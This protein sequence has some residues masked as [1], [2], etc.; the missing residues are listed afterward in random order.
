GDKLKIIV[1]CIY[2]SPASDPAEF[3]RTLEALLTYLSK[4][5]DHIILAGGDLNGDFDITT[6]KATVAD[7][8]NLLRQFNC[9]C[10]NSSP[11]RGN[12]CLDN[13]FVNCN[14]D[15]ILCN[16]KSFP[17]SDNDGLVIGLKAIDHFA[18][19]EDSTNSFEKNNSFKLVLP[20][21]CVYNIIEK[22]N[23]VNWYFLSHQYFCYA[24]TIVA[25]F[26]QL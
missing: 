21:H 8:L 19:L 17:Y 10:L 20:K 26:F 7:F 18:P 22:L 25:Y 23:L 24:A 11:T 6:T 15:G 16:I 5:K 12:S 2:R 4:W 14:S 13:V 9:Y 1:V 3:L